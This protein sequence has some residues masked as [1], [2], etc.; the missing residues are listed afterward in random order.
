MRDQSVRKYQYETGHSERW[1]I[2][3]AGG[4][5]HGRTTTAIAATKQEK[6]VKG[7]GPC[8]TASIRSPSAT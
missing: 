6:M 5:F 3:T 2:I 7:F 8:R 4:A 1:R